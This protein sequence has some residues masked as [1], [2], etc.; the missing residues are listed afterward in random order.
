[1]IL[2]IKDETKNVNVSVEVKLDS[3][4]LELVKTDPE[5]VF[6]AIL[7]TIWSELAFQI[8]LN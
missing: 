3:K 5:G 1:M 4:E 7:G 6:K 8:K 2:N